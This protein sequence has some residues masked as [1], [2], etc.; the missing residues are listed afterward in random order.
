MKFLRVIMR[1]I[2]IELAWLISKEVLAAINDPNM[3][4]DDVKKVAESVADR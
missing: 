2:K 3:D 1:R 4:Y